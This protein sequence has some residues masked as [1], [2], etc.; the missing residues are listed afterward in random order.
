MRTSGSL[1]IGGGLAGVLTAYILAKDGQN[2]TIA[3]KKTLGSGVTALTT[4]FITREL[5]TASKDLLSMFG[6]AKRDLIYSS[7]QSAIDRIEQI[8]KSEKIDCDFVRCPLFIYSSN[9]GQ[10]KIIKIIPNQAKFSAS[11]FLKALAKKAKAY[12]AK[13]LEHTEIKKIPVGPEAPKVM[14]MTYAPLGNPIKTFA[15][16]GMYV[17]YAM[18]VTNLK[19]KFK[20]G[21]YT[22]TENPY[23]YF[24]IDGNT[25]I[26]GG[27]D[28]RQ[29]LPVN[30]TKQFASLKRHVEFLLGRK[31]FKITRKWTGPILEPSDGLALIGE[32]DAKRFVATAFSGNGMTYAMIAAQMARDWIVGKPNPWT[33]L[34][35]PTRIPTIK[36]LAI[37]ARDYTGEH[38]GALITHRR[39]NE[40]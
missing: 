14:I 23:H 27:E 13:I 32:L 2:V 18:E 39:K 5:D 30:K 22:D 10:F 16:K 26:I 20:E 19:R 17:S 1:I 37:K 36:Q 4:A 34:Y 29:I 12:G 15:K 33:K 25:M 3:E 21:I 38:I 31:D 35:D 9:K 6:Q 28:H 40:G 8:I 11:K 24:R 7:H